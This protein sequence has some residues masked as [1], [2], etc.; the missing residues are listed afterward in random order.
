MTA[1]LAE[2]ELDTARQA[3]VAAYDISR[4]ANDLAVLYRDLLAAKRR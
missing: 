4:L 3:V 1:A 2:P